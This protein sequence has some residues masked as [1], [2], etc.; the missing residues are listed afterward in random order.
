LALYFVDNLE[1]E[2]DLSSFFQIPFELT[3]SG[4][5]ISLESEIGP[6]KFLVDTGTTLNYI[7]PYCLKDKNLENDP[8][9]NLYFP[10]NQLSYA[11][12]NFK[13]QSFYP[14]E[15][16]AEFGKIDGVLGMRFLK[17]LSFAIDFKNQV[18]YLKKLGD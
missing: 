11:H 8:L 13:E 18:F 9:E 1:N 10:M 4:I 5:V 16:P 7:K 15:I 17:D 2:F 12:H 14:I 3:E 6:L